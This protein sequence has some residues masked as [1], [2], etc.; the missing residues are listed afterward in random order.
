MTHSITEVE[1]LWHYWNIIYL[2]AL[3]ALTSG[4][5]DV[6]KST[7]VIKDLTAS[8]LRRTSK[9]TFFFSF[10]FTHHTFLLFSGW[11]SSLCKI[12]HT[13]KQN[14]ISF[15]ISSDHQHRPWSN[16][17]TNNPIILKIQFFTSFGTFRYTRLPRSPGARSHTTSELKPSD[18]YLILLINHSERNHH[19]SNPY[20]K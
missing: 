11:Q 8:V 20:R 9:N 13:G 19:H 12:S 7:T 6:H 15:R 2:P 4:Y 17:S 18:E 3:T 5:T 10:L 14:R 1:I 16:N